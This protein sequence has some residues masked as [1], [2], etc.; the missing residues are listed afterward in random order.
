M[1]DTEFDSE[2][3]RLHRWLEERYHQS[4]RESLQ[5]GSRL[6]LEGK[7]LE[8]L[9]LLQRAHRLKPD[10]P[11][12]VLNLSGA[13]ILAGKHHHAVAILEAALRQF[14]DNARL[15]ANLGAA[16]L[17]NLLTA[18]EEQQMRALKAFER[19]LEIDP[20]AHSVA[21]NIGL[22]YQGRGETRMA[23]AAF[24][25]AILANPLDHDARTLL[26]QLEQSIS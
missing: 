12:I 4:L 8:A 9:P 26:S 2:L 25:R 7:P 6:L 19:A 14:P 5:Q 24:R 20:L 15:W 18:T 10:D 23:I 22:I 21:Y 11:D 16:Y 13:Y 17:G 1:S 3:S